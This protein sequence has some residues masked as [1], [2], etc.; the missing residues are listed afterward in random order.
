MQGTKHKTPIG[1]IQKLT[2]FTDPPL[3]ENKQTSELPEPQHQCLDSEHQFYPFLKAET[4][5]RME[6]GTA[7]MAHAI[8]E[9]REDLKKH[10]LQSYEETCLETTKAPVTAPTSI[11][12]HLLLYHTPV[13]KASVTTKGDGAQGV[14]A[15][16]YYTQ[17]GL[18]TIYNVHLVSNNQ[19]KLVF[20]LFYL[21]GAASSWSQLM[22]HKVF[23]GYCFECF[24]F[25]QN[26]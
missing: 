12:A 17:F 4:L 19:S 13:A 10:R 26:L 20:S 22:N 5:V 24:Q 1:D 16:V 25:T 9:L 18:Y 15:K 21:N 14:K 7:K 8:R 6:Y 23:E 11:P 2:S 3:I